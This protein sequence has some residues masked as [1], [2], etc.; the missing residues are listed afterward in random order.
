MLGVNIGQQMLTDPLYLKI[1]RELTKGQA[2]S[3]QQAMAPW[4]YS[5]S[6]TR[7]L[8]NWMADQQLHATIKKLTAAL[9][10]QWERL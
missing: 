6:H 3:V 4:D 5:E 1:I 2:V 7:R 10:F 9:P 8:L